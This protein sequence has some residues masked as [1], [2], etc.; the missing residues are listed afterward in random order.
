[1]C[2]RLEGHICEK[3]GGFTAIVLVLGRVP[4]ESHWNLTTRGKDIA[5]TLNTS[6]ATEPF[7]MFNLAQISNRTCSKN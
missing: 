3:R 5:E 7:P 4:V 6:G 1:M 2:I